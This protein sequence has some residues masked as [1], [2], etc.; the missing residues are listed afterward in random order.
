MIASFYRAFEDLHRGSRDV[1]KQRQ[2]VYLPFIRP[3][4]DV[5]PS[6]PIIDLGCGR[7][8]WLE[9]LAGQG[10]KAEGVDIDNAM[11]SACRELGLAVN[12]S[13][14]IEYIKRLPDASQLAVSGFHI[15]EHIPFGK[16]HEL[17]IES[18][19]VLVPG[20]VLILETPNPENLVVGS[21]SFYLDP[22]HER[23]IP[24]LLLTF[25]A[26]HVGFHRTKILRLQESP[27]LLTNPSPDLLSVLNGVSPDY[28]VVAQKSGPAE[29][30]EALE[31]EFKADRGLTLATLAARY[32]QRTEARV[33][34]AESCSA[35]AERYA[36]ETAALAAEIREQVAK[37]EAHA[38][39]ADA[40]AAQAE[41]RAAE[42]EAY[43]ASA[44]ARAAEAE[45]HAARANAG[46]G[47]AEVKTYEAEARVSDLLNST[48]WRVTSPLRQFKEIL[49]RLN[50]AGL[51]SRSNAVLQHTALYI[52]RRPRLK[53]K[54]L[55][56]VN[57]F[58]FLKPL[59]A[60]ASG[61]TVVSSSIPTFP[62]SSPELAQLTPRARRIYMNLQSAIDK[63]R[64][65]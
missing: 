32:Q 30:L 17:V 3:L 24:P 43:A 14:A 38:A 54:V 34:S 23:P 62:A 36:A 33:I 48:S 57:R 56:L 18:L 37:A 9:L 25:V 65:G 64:A 4:K 29:L 12:T 41:A 7:G 19:R 53:R 63:Q 46:A 16:L 45:N 49:R 6:C 10:F 15:V 55:L 50:L 59:V 2:E 11:L 5:Y 28:A 51:S 61:V 21:C 8:E 1:I 31:A 44:D 60:K 35:Q 27:D 58:T 40:R 52:R 22:T 26:E 20:G 47:A 13:D 39:K 42:A